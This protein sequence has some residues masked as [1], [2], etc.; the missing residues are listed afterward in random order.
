MSGIKLY[1]DNFSVATRS[2]TIMLDKLD[3]KYE[4]IHIDVLKGMNLAPSFQK[5]NPTQMIPVLIDG[6][7][8]LTES[9]AICTYL[10][11]KF[12]SDLYPSI[13][14]DRARVDEMLYYDAC[15]VSPTFQNLMRPVLQGAD[16]ADVEVGKM[17]GIMHHLN[18]VLSSTGFMAKTEQLSVADIV[19][20]AMISTLEAVAVIDLSIYRNIVIWLEKCKSSIPNYDKAN[21]NGLKKV[22]RYYLVRT[23]VAK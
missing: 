17:M 7:L 5:I 2:V 1:G 23:G 19:L 16:V 8:K 10:A 20:F 14:V 6:S 3:L 22:V 18:K 9:R 11:T 21:G 12:S 13:L 15:M 4:M